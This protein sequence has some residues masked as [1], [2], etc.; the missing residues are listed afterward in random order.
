VKYMSTVGG[1]QFG[2]GYGL[3]G[4]LIQAPGADTVFAYVGIGGVHSD[5]DISH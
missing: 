4:L 1:L 5:M 3:V 2:L